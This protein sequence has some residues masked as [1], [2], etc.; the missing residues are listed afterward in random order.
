MKRQLLIFLQFTRQTGHR[1]PHLEAAMA[2]Y[3]ALLKQMGHSE[4]Q[5]AA[6]LKRL[7]PEMFDQPGG[8]AEEE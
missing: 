5:I 2:N 8:Q 4:D 1:H 3:V 6:R 7:A